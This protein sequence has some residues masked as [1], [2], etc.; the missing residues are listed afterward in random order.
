MPPTWGSAGD[1]QTPRS[2]PLQ[3]AGEKVLVGGCLGAPAPER[4]AGESKPAGESLLWESLLAPRT[5]Y[6]L[7]M[8]GH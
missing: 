5:V 2:P 7:L 1:V 3:S 6:L 8:T 4:G